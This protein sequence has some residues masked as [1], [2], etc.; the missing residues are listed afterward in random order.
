MLMTT[1]NPCLSSS[2][3]RIMTSTANFS[4]EYKE[5]SWT[6]LTSSSHISSRQPF[7]QSFTSGHVKFQKVVTRAMSGAAENNPL[8]GLPID[9][10]GQTSISFPTVLGPLSL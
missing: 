1:I 6:K 10:R 3:K 2:R 7:L 4:T 5:A 9:L 8:S